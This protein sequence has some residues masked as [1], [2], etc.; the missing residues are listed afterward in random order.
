MLEGRLQ[1]PSK[2]SVVLHLCYV[3][4]IPFSHQSLHYSWWLA[5]QLQQAANLHFIWGELASLM[6]VLLMACHFPLWKIK[7]K[8]MKEG[9]I[10][11]KICLSTFVYRLYF[12]GSPIGSLYSSVYLQT[13]LKNLLLAWNNYYDKTGDSES[14]RNPVLPWQR[15]GNA[16]FME[17][18]QKCWLY[19][20]GW[21]GKDTLDWTRKN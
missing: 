2:S 1:V 8:R 7:C 5:V 4:Y 3:K 18:E 12:V 20:S 17:S 21:V 13:S 14:W 10:S 19:C 11:V 15:G 6:N 16:Y 9:G